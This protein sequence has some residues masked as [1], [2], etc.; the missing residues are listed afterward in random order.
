MTAPS[1]PIW[2]I[3]PIDGKRVILT[4]QLAAAIAFHEEYQAQRNRHKK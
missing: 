3:S 2:I 1:K 4:V